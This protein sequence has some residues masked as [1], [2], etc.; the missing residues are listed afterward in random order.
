MALAAGQLYHTDVATTWDALA[1]LFDRDGLTRDAPAVVA[2]VRGVVAAADPVARAGMLADLATGLAK[3]GLSTRVLATLGMSANAAAPPRPR[4]RGAAAPAP[5]PG[6]GSRPDAPAPRP[7]RAAGDP[8]RGGHRDDPCR[9]PKTA[10]CVP[11]CGRTS[12][13]ATANGWSSTTNERSAT[14]REAQAVRPVLRRASPPDAAAVPAARRRVASAK[15]PRHM[16][17]RHG[18]ILEGRRARKPW[19]YLDATC[20]GGGPRRPARRLVPPHATAASRRGCCEGRVVCRGGP[21]RAGRL[22]A[23]L[24]DGAGPAARPAV[25]RRR[26]ARVRP[27]LFHRSVP[28]SCGGRGS[29][30][31][32]RRACSSTAPNRTRPRRP[33]PA[34]S[35]WPCRSSSSRSCLPRCCRPRSP[36]FPR[37]PRCWSC[38]WS[39]DSCG[40]RGRPPGERAIDHAWRFLAFDPQRG[41]VPCTTSPS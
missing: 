22:P 32:R 18:R 35:C 20:A 13:R 1:P 37:R 40:R 12:P 8:A 41:Q 26:R 10:S 27:R 24:G 6:G 15:L 14:L 33:R 29:A 28:R 31:S 3:L 4:T 19:Q 11:A 39:I 2:L 36:S 17:K 21:R 23:V 38:S 34:A 5:G 30:S 16:W 9:G 7:P 25:R